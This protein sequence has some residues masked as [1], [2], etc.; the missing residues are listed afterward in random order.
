M[1]SKLVGGGRRHMQV[2]GNPVSLELARLIGSSPR[3]Q[4]ERGAATADL[5]RSRVQDR[6]QVE[7]ETELSVW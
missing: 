1:N 5:L 6:F 4:G 2:C 3:D 7:L